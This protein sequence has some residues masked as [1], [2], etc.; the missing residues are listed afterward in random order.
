MGSVGG[1]SS[2]RVGG[3]WAGGEVGAV[4]SPGGGAAESGAGAD[5][6]PSAGPATDSAAGAFEVGGDLSSHAART[7]RAL[8]PRRRADRAFMQGSTG[9]HANV[10]RGEPS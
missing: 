1:L 3:V 7:V 5:A 6:A 4:D 10:T 8:A 2:G 9:M